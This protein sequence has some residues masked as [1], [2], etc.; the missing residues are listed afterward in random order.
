MLFDAPLV[1]KPGR[2]SRRNIK[3]LL[4]IYALRGLTLKEISSPQIMN[5]R[6]STLKRYAKIAGLEFPDYKPRRQK[7]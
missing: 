5:R 1:E 7:V 2:K 6:I 4:Q 3:E